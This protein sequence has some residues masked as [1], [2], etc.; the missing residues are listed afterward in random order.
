MTGKKVR[1]RDPRVILQNVGDAVNQ[2]GAAI[3]GLMNNERKMWGTFDNLYNR[4]I[5]AAKYPW[6][7]GYLLLKKLERANQR[8]MLA[9]EALAAEMKEKAEAE[10]IEPDAPELEYEP[11]PD[12]SEIIQRDKTIVAPDGRPA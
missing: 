5:T 12:Q 8:A 4:V 11:E 3:M 1:S 9:Q 10:G 2:Q 6:P 7:I